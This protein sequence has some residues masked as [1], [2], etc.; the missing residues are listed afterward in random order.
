MHLARA[1]MADHLDDLG[2]GRA[3]HDRIVNQDDPLAFEVGAVG[4]VLEPYTQMADLVCR[5][6][7]GAP[8]IMVAD[9]PELER[10][11]RFGGKAE[12]RRNARIGHRHDD[13][14]IDRGFARQLATNALPRLVDAVAFEHAVGARKINVLKDAK[15]LWHVVERLDAAHAAGADDHDLAGFDIAHEIGADDVEGAG[16]GGYDPRIA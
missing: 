12:R 13:I 8:D 11:P 15:P 14:S 9:D 4:V 5:L 1:G 10:Q 3:A 7:K 16:L 6:D 2:R